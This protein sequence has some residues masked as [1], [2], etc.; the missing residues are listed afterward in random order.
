[1]KNDEKKFKQNIDEIKDKI[2]KINI[3]IADKKKIYINIVNDYKSV[4]K[5]FMK[6]DIYMNQIYEILGVMNV[7]HI[8]NKF[9]KLR[10]KYNELSLNSTFK[11]K[12]IISLNGELTD[13]NKTYNN[14]LENIKDKKLLEENDNK[15]IKYND[16]FENFTTMIEKSK[17][18]LEEKYDVFKDKME[19]FNKCIH[20]I[21]RI[22]DNI[23]NS[24]THSKDYFTQY[25]DINKNRNLLIQNY[26]EYFY[27]IQH[28]KNNFYKELV[29]KKFLKF[30]IFILN[31]LNYRIK[32]ITSDIHSFIY[33]KE[34]KI[35]SKKNLGEKN[36]DNS[37]IELNT[38][39]NLYIFPF[40]TKK[41]KNIYINELKI[42]KEKI[43]EKKKFYE[44]TD[45]NCIK[46]NNSIDKNDP[47]Y[48]PSIDRDILP[49]N[50]S[51][52]SIS[53][54]DFLYNYYLH[55]KKTILNNKMKY[56][57]V[58]GSTNSFS[59]IKKIILIMN[60]IH[61]QIFLIAQ[62]KPNIMI[63]IIIILI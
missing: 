38:N 12:E 42:Q 48:L 50:R 10:Q 56:R 8:L 14:I 63:V 57:N 1:M 6:D 4:K 46:S 49:R 34:K 23:F 28:N 44:G 3:I 9:K 21:L 20:L 35:E 17:N 16:K 53:T 60:L 27:D 24:T 43:E 61:H 37:D 25:N 18:I 59:I 47:Y 31:E 45:K 41:F 26:Q 5:I 13:L 55:Y 15:K 36:S 19:I 62:S 29:N 2:N 30:I 22:I 40:N 52:D 32:N 11:S 54:K 33:K 7:D 58:G 51:M 39:N